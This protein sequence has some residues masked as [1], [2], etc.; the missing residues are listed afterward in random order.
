MLSYKA[1]LRDCELYPHV[2]ERWIKAITKLRENGKYTN[3]NWGGH[4]E[5][6]EAELIFDQ[7]ISGKTFDEW[8]AKKYPKV[9]YV[10]PSLFD[11]ANNE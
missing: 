8:Y 4:N 1:A 5:R 3:H 10:T 6:E 2:K 11:E 7:W 9:Q